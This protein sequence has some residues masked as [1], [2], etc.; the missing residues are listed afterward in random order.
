MKLKSKLFTFVCQQLRSD[1]SCQT[2]SGFAS[3]TGRCATLF[4]IV[5]I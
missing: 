3:Q 2:F 1:Q 4:D 5:A